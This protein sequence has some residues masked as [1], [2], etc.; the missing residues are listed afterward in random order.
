MLPPGL[1][2]AISKGDFSPLYYLYGE[3]RLDIDKTV[4]A[5]K[6]ALF[7]SGDPGLGLEIFDAQVDGASEIL[8]AART[9]AFGASRKMVVVKNAH[10]FKKD[11]ADK[12][13]DYFSGPSKQAC[14]VFTAEKQIFRGKLLT[15]LKKSGRVEKFDNPKKHQS[16][17]QYIREAFQCRGR[18]LSEDAQRFMEENIGKDLSAIANEAEKIILFCGDKKRIELFDVESVLTTGSRN[19]IFDLVEAIGMGDVQ[20]SV[21]V[22]GIM[23]SEGNHPLQILAMISRQFRQIT[24]AGAC[25]E[26]RMSKKEVGQKIGV[27]KNFLIEKIIVQARGWNSQSL[28]KV[29]AAIAATDA[30]LK[31]SRANGR[32]IMEDLVFRLV[33]LR[34]RPYA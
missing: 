20:T 25:A 31:S 1:K 13:A 21:L 33:D 5:L 3:N 10:V 23:I 4:E 9:L 18:Q 24:L 19:D 34:G 29:F 15:A 27:Y 6:T 7:P 2:K 14:L 8:N 12:F 28:A 30:R 32:L 22:L 17:K 26:K 16:V 11:Q